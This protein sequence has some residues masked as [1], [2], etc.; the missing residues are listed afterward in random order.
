MMRF[1]FEMYHKH[2]AIKSQQGLGLASALF[3]ILVLI[4]LIAAMN[5]LNEINTTI[6]GR[7][8]LS[9]R[10][11]YSAESAAQ[12]AAVRVLNSEQGLGVCDDNFINNQMFSSVG[13]NQ[14]RAD[15]SCVLQT[16]NGD[17]FYT[18]TSTAQC[19]SGLDMARRIIQIR[20]KP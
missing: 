15:V 7:E 12:S 13:L 16:V 5:Q 4:L 11:F 14:C 6:Y 18:L 9:V 3:L 8:W 1:R 19:G 20:L 10:A 2:S 17:T